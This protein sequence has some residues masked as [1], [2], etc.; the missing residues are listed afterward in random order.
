M[1]LW[2]EG[3][4]STVKAMVRPV[5]DSFETGVVNQ[6]ELSWTGSLWVPTNLDDFPE[7][8]ADVT[9]VV[10]SGT[11]RAFSL[12][13]ADVVHLS[14]PGRAFPNHEG[15]MVPDGAAAWWL[16][17]PAGVEGGTER[18]WRVTHRYDDNNLGQLRSGWRT[19]SWLNIRP[20]LIINQ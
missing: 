14:G 6:H 12:S 16:R 20:A 10:S 8:E 7:V 19:T 4:E 2:Y 15:R 3:L 1:N 9:R 13:L 17:T 11:P 5:A 18:A